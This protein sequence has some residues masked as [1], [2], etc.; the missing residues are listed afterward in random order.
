[1]KSNKVLDVLDAVLN[2]TNNDHVGSM[3]TLVQF[4]FQGAEVIIKNR[5]AFNKGDYTIALNKEGN[6][7]ETLDE[8]DKPVAYALQ[9]LWIQQFV[10]MSK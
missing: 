6:F 1:M 8:L 10:T 9:A 4:D 2:R 5:S 7:V 3:S